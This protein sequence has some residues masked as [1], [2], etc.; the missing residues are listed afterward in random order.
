MSDV[1]GVIEAQARGTRAAS[2][3]ETRELEEAG[4][5]QRG[6][7][8]EL[9]ALMASGVAVAEEGRREQERQR[10]ALER[11]AAA[12]GAAGGAAAAAHPVLQHLWEGQH[13]LLGVRLWGEEP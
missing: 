3:Q 11:G 9:D 10:L 2:E 12:A 1:E 7:Q 6:L 13:A 8:A 4:A 5:Q